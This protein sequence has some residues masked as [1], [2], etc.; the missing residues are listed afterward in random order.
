MSLKKQ[1]AAGIKWTLGLSVFQ[2]TLFF[3][4]TMVLAR[5]LEP[6]TFG[7]Y[8]LAFVVINGLSLFKS[9]GFIG[10]MSDGRRYY[11][12]LIFK[13]LRNPQQLSLAVTF[14]VYGFHFRKV[15]AACTR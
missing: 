3:G 15:F 4:T 8:A 1:T 5:I 6:S 7:L 2:R 13:S 14:A 9:M 11:W 12:K 10:V